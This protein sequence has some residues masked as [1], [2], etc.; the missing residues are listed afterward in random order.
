MAR[1]DTPSLP[2][3]PLLWWHAVLPLFLPFPCSDGARKHSGRGRDQR[4]SKDVGTTLPHLHRGRRGSGCWIQVLPF[5]HGFLQGGT[6]VAEQLELELPAAARRSGRAGC[7]RSM[8]TAASSLSTVGV[9]QQRERREG[10]GHP[11]GLFPAMLHLSPV[12]WRQSGSTSPDL[13][14]SRT[15]GRPWSSPSL[16][17][18]PLLPLPCWCRAGAH[19]SYSFP[20]VRDGGAGARRSGLLRR[21][22][23]EVVVPSRQWPPPARIK[24]GRS[25]DGE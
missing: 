16:V 24:A 7:W 8:S 2:P 3:L 14:L 20:R 18:A 23:D 9:L 10:S 17:D 13:C 15:V 25:D 6:E 19:R 22:V 1:R 12:W 5:L 4:Q 11:N 21:R